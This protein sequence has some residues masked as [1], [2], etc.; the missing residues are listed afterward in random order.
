MWYYYSHINPHSCF[1]TPYN[2]CI[3]N[4]YYNKTKYVM[5]NFQWFHLVKNE[6]KAGCLLKFQYFIHLFNF[7]RKIKITLLC[8]WR[9]K[10]DYR[11]KLDIFECSHLVDIYLIHYSSK[12]CTYSAGKLNNGK[13]WHKSSFFRRIYLLFSLYISLILIPLKE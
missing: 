1:N 8:R 2:S 4:F 12:M 11:S 5:A 7:V 9:L 10:T 6:V 13:Y 3:N